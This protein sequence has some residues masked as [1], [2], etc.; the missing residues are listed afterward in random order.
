MI[1][2]GCSGWNYRHWREVFYSEGL[3]VKRWFAHYVQA[4]N[5]VEVNASFY[6]LL[7]ADT[8]ITTS[9]RMRSRT[10][11]HL[12]KGGMSKVGGSRT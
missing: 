2:I 12:S 6:R 9:T 4:F 3:P 5:P 8:S 1:R 7:T 10:R 11:R